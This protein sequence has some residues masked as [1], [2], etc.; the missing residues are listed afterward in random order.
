M[1]SYNS[2]VKLHMCQI[3]VIS[4]RGREERIICISYHMLC[5]PSGIPKRGIGESSQVCCKE[6]FCTKNCFFKP[7]SAVFNCRGAVDTLFY[8][9]S[10]ITDCMYA[11]LILC[12][13]ANKIN[14]VD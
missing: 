2:V 3:L 4:D 13:E 9:G 11:D 8:S 12:G 10:V 1:I 14:K 6:S 7:Q 5:Y